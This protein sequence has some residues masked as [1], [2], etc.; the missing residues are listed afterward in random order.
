MPL[1]LEQ[2]EEIGFI[3]NDGPHGCFGAD[4]EALTGVPQDKVN[5]A[6]QAAHLYNPEHGVQ[7][8]GAELL[9]RALGRLGI[10]FIEVLPHFDPFSE[11]KTALDESPVAVYKR[12]EILEHEL[13]KSDIEGVVLAYPCRRAPDQDPFTH[14]VAI[15]SV[16]GEI[17][18]K[19]FIY[20]DPS[21]LRK[22]DGDRIGGVFA[23]SETEMLDMLTPEPESSQ[24]LFSVYPVCAYAISTR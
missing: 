13:Q 12:L 24:E 2:C 11:D 15:A 14:F 7:I 4:I 1:R 21:E 16:E 18:D 5:D 20:M 6:L 3:E 10:S 9:N 19:T 8:V 22:P 23:A 17:G